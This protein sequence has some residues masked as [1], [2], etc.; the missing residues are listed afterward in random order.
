MAVFLHTSVLK[1]KLTKHCN[2]NKIVGKHFFYYYIN[3]IYNSASY[4]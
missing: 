1:K 3:F 4:Y 2:H